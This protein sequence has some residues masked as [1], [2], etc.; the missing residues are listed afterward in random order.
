MTTQPTEVI[1]LILTLALILVI[2]VPLTGVLV[3]LRANY[4]P[5]ALR[6]DVEGGAQAHTGPVIHS[7]FGMM[8]RV[9][10]IEVGLC[11]VNRIVR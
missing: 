3:R 1:F 6:L 11:C 10:R 7:Y 9:Y 5:K 2:T 4:N 8:A